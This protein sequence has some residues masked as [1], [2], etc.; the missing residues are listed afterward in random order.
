MDFLMIAALLGGFALAAL[1]I[2]WCF[3][4]VESEE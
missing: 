3:Y 2:H 1:L 4:Q